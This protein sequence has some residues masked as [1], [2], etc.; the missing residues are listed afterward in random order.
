MEWTARNPGTDAALKG[1]AFGAGGGVA[2][3][4]RGTVATSP[5]G[6]AW[7]GASLG[8]QDLEAVAYGAPGWVAVGQGGVIFASPDGRTWERAESPTAQHLWCVAWLKEQFVAAEAHLSA[9]DVRY[10]RRV[11]NR[12]K[13]EEKAAARVEPKIKLKV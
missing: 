9:T 1:L 6:A 3:G 4:A 8:G 11:F 2:V 5:D 7:S 10:M 13:K 12:R